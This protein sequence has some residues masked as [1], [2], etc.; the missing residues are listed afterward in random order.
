MQSKCWKKQK[1]FIYIYNFGNLNREY[2]KKMF[3]LNNNNIKIM[4][5]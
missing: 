1:F 3:I 4:Y 2:M 5:F